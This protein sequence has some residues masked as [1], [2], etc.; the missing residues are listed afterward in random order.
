MAAAVKMGDVDVQG[1]VY[2]GARRLR[3]RTLFSEADNVLHWAFPPGET[4]ALEGFFPQAVG[5]FGNPT[6]PGLTD[7]ISSNTIMG[8]ISPD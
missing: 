1:R 4:A 6:S 3:T 8:I 7:L 2:A 5:R